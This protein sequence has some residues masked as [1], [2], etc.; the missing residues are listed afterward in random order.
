MCV[1]IQMGSDMTITRID[2]LSHL[3]IPA[4]ILL[5]D[6]LIGTSQATTL[7]VTTTEDKAY[8]ILINTKV[9]LQ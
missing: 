6:P 3:I 8:I 9:L 4:I 7:I 5:G 2:H 1:Q